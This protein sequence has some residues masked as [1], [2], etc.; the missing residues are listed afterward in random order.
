MPDCIFCKIVAG[1]IPSKKVMEDDHTIVIQDINP[2]A[3]VHVLVI[4]KEHYTD[5]TDM[6]DTVYI[7]YMN[8]VRN[9]IKTQKIRQFRIVH[10]GKGAQFIA[11]AHT[12][13]MGSVDVD[14]KL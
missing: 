7:Q 8:S 6:G 12:H 13:V 2:A 11:H 5:I 9:V 3:P 1:E 14:R 10:N 4:S